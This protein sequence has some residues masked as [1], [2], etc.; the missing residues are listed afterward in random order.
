MRPVA[1]DFVQRYE[2]AHGKQSVSVFAANVW[3][4]GIV[5]RQALGKALATARPGSPAFRAALRDALETTRDVVTTQ[6]VCTMSA[7]D[8]S[9]YDRRA[10][11]D[12]ADPGG[13]WKIV[14]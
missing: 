9:G 11:W 2:A 4:A 5:L 14:D 7:T 3:D 8:H 10:R 1:A 13:D 6:G 12:G